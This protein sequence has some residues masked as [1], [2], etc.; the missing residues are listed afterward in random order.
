MDSLLVRWATAIT[1]SPLV[2]WIGGSVLIYVVGANA[3]WLLGNQSRRAPVRWL[4]QVGRFT[5]YL[6]IPYL[7]LGGWPRQPYQGLL[8]L[9]D[10]GIVGLG[11]RWSVIRWLEAAAV[12]L[13]WGALAL[14]LLGL[15]WVG[16]NR[17]DGR[18]SLVFSASRWW[19]VL[20]GVLYLEVHWAFYRGALSVMLDDAYAGAFLGLGLLYLEWSLDPL[21]R[22]GWRLGS[23]AAQ[24]WLHAALVF[25]IALLFLFTRNLWVC[26]TVHLMVEFSMRQLVRERARLRLAPDSVPAA[27]S[28]TEP[29]TEAWSEV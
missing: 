12:G 21:W 1:T 22:Q 17:H 10:M 24:R 5:F 19:V 11:G 14:V 23:R 18:I 7:A 2:F 26:L 9:E 6:V 3:F 16:A 15:A 29:S 4:I 13:G 8:S 25:V 27:E 20:V 28:S